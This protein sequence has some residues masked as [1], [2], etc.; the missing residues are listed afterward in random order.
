MA[1]GGFLQTLGLAAG[2]NII[3]GQQLDAQKA[4]TQLKQQQLQMGAM[5]I[6]EKQQQQATQKAIGAAISSDLSLDPSKAANASAMAGEYEKGAGLALKNGDF[7]S[8]ATMTD[9]AKG[10]LQEA[11]D[12]AT[13]VAQQ[14]AVKQED[15]AKAAD[16]YSSA[17][18]SE[19]AADVARKAVAAGVNPTTIPS[20]GTPQFTT[21]V[22]AQKLAGMKSGDVAKLTETV[23]ATNLKAQ[24]QIQN[25][26]D[27]EQDVRLSQANLAAN[28]E[29]MRS[30]ALM[31]LEVRRDAA[32]NRAPTTKDFNGATY[33]H[34]PSQQIKGVRDTPDPAWVKIGGAKQ[35][36]T[37]MGQNNA[38][39]QSA[40]EA[41]RGI[42]LT[43]KL[44]VG[45]TA[46]PFADLTSH[47]I[48]QSI[49]KTG[50]N[51]LTPSESKIY[52]TMTAG[53]GLEAARVL[54]LGAGRGANQATIN[55]MQ[56]I[57]TIAPGDD[58]ATAMFK[59]ANA[60]DLIRNRL[61]SLPETTDPKVNATRE[62][63]VKS[64]NKIPTPDAILAAVQD[65]TQVNKLLGIQGR[66]SDVSQ[67]LTSEAETAPAL[68]ASGGLPSGWSVK[69]H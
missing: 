20:P 47:T 56:H 41:L 32:A 49:A 44:A 34:D 18:T 3:V 63:L 52:Q 24:I 40:S 2:N 26:A 33:E 65:P 54:T 35:T 68:P 27:H 11:K 19:G 7:S 64:L 28:R 4:E 57:V 55:E 1:L 17:P 30:I 67:R 60:A 50:T 12:Q 8:A 29:S 22:N 16:S 42:E 37:Q 51:A 69:E 5:A 15:L 62:R 31:G 39:V 25:H 38:V 6:Q 66:M 14:K 59:Y 43:G 58:K 46:G 21:W 10:K 9:L 53:L 23:R 45:V 61:D 36:A 48:L 13:Y